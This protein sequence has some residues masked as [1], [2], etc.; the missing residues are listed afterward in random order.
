MSVHNGHKW[1]IYFQKFDKHVQK[2]G[3]VISPA[4]TNPVQV[5]VMDNISEQNF[6][7]VFE[8]H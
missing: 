5:R 1:D 3:I 2:A 4:E 8:L 7:E 6:I